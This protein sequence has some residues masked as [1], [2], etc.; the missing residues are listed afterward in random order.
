MLVTFMKTIQ[1]EGML[2]GMPSLIVRTKG[3][4][5]NCIWCDNSLEDDS[6]EELS[7]MQ[8]VEKVEE[9]AATYVI[10][11]GGEPTLNKEMSALTSALKS[12]GKHVTIE[13][14]GTVICNLDADLVSISPK[15][16]NSNPENVNSELYTNY[17]KKRINLQALDYYINNF[18]VQFKFV[19]R[20]KVDFEEAIKLLNQIGYTKYVNVFMMPMAKTAAELEKIQLEIVELCVEFGLRYANRLQLQLWD[21]DRNENEY[22]NE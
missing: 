2:Q 7:V 15:L 13:T 3:C 17:E 9:F 1:G 18:D 8:I 6:Y 22:W 20:D 10:I 21:D 4:N 5:L 16:K 11:T 19:V 12:I 14:N